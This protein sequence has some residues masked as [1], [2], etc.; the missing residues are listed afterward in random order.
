MT[1]LYLIRRLAKLYNYK[2]ASLLLG[3]ESR[4]ALVYILRNVRLVD[5]WTVQQGQWQTWRK[6]WT[7]HSERWPV[8]QVV[9]KYSRAESPPEPS[10]TRSVTTHHTAHSSG[11][12]FNFS[13]PLLRTDR[14]ENPHKYRIQNIGHRKPSSLKFAETST[15]KIKWIFFLCSGDNILL[16]RFIFSC[17]RSL[18]VVMMSL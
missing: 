15:P 1:P 9:R 14:L 10:L 3:W 16:R 6:F 18:L 8:G 5:V 13:C 2:S 4:V 11:I 12:M 7:Q 17:W